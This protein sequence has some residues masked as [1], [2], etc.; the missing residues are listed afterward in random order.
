MR[1]AIAVGLVFTAGLVTMWCIDHLAVSL[2]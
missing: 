2:R 1:G